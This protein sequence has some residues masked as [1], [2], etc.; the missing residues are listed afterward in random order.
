MSTETDIAVINQKLDDLKQDTQEIKKSLFGNG[1]TGLKDRVNTLEV[2]FWII[3][4]M[5]IPITICGI[6]MLI[7]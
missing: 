3:F 7:E 5:L 4:V 2:K 1:K 6:R